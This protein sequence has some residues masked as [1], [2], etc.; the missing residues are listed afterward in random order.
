MGIGHIVIYLNATRG[1]GAGCKIDV[2]TRARAFREITELIGLFLS[3]SA[4]QRSRVLDLNFVCL[5]RGE[6]TGGT[7]ERFA[8]D[9]A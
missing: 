7:K 1:W 8:R 2:E 6:G 3:A 5:Y 4:D 9:A